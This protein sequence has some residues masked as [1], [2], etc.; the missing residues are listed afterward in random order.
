M[1]FQLD[2]TLGKDSILISEL[3]LCQARLINNSDFPW[4]ILVPKIND[5]SEIT[6]LSYSEY[7]Q[8]NREIRLVAAALQNQYTP[9]KLNIATLGNVVSQLHI[10]IIARFK[11]DALFP[12]PVWGSKFVHYEKKEMEETLAKL[13]KVL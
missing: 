5:I 8:L 13:R 9:D 7:E 1:N 11:S 2:K 4:V 10:H 12:K 3:D 6:D